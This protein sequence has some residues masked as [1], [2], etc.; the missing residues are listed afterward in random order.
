MKEEKRILRGFLPANLDSG[1]GG[2]HRA[3]ESCVLC[4]IGQRHH[5]VIVGDQDHIYRGEVKQLSLKTEER[6]KQHVTLS[7]SLSNG[8]KTSVLFLKF[9]LREYY[10]FIKKFRG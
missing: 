6:D 4:D 3:S 8:R 9:I 7:C 1:L 5:A 2:V 10:W